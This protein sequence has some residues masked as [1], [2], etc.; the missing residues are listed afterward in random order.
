MPI[1]LFRIYQTAD[2][3]DVWGG[4]SQV[5]YLLG[6]SVSMCVG[7]FVIGIPTY[8]GN[9]SYSLNF[10]GGHFWQPT[11]RMF[12]GMYVMHLAVIQYNIAQ[13]YALQYLDNFV[14][15]NY[16]LADIFFIFI[17]SYLFVAC[18]ELPFVVLTKKF[19]W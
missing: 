14:M 10:F 12:I 2:K 16:A 17:F 9:T 18:Y 15:Q 19:L 3:E 11:S 7:A 5:F 8:L 1:L 6:G 4:W 13:S